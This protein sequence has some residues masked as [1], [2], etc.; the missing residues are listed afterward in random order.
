MDAINGFW[1]GDYGFDSS[2]SDYIVIAP[3]PRDND[4]EACG[5]SSAQPD[6]APAQVPVSPAA[7]T[8]ADL[9]QMMINMQTQFNE[10]MLKL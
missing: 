4:A 8:T 10:R 5:S 2:D 1:D 7:P 9:M 6:P 3:P